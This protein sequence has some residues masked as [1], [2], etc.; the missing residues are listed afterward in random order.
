MTVL[1]A[2]QAL[3]RIKGLSRTDRRVGAAIVRDGRAPATPS[4]LTGFAASLRI[5]PND[6]TASIKRLRAA[7]GVTDS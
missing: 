4:Q 3:R 5:K 2:W 7:L 6:A 1:A